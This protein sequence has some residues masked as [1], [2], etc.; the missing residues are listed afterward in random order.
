[1]EDL[2]DAEVFTILDLKSAYWHIPLKPSDKH[3]TAFVVPNGKYQW[4]V[5]PFGLTDA[6][7]SLTYVMTNIL[8]DFKFVKSFYDDCILYGKRSE[9]LDLIREVLEKF[10][11]YGIHINLK[12]CQFMADE[13]TFIGYIINKQGV[14]PDKTKVT[15]IVNFKRPENVSELKTFLGMASY[16]RKFIPEFS[17]HTAVLYGLLKKNVVFE[18]SAECE[19]SFVYVKT[20]LESPELLI[21]PNFSKPFVLLSDASNNA[22]TITG[23]DQN[24][25]GTDQN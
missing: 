19:S 16:F 23:T 14:K 24:R 3:K 9:H 11:E 8:R 22:L 13:V 17:E 6:A 15:D 4:T 10:A 12:K 5:M 2:N 7:F 18:W 1:M 21:H 20:K 25:A